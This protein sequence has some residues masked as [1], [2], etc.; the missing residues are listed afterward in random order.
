MAQLE[1]IGSLWTNIDKNGNNYMNGTIGGKKVIIFSN[2]NK[3]ED[4]HPDW[5]VYLQKSKDELPPKKE[6]E[7]VPF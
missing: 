5:N 1:S 7:D 6:E 4:K 3:K 2:K